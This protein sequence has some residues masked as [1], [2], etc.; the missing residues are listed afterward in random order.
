MEQLMAEQLSV[1]VGGVADATPVELAPAADLVERTENL[2]NHLPAPDEPLPGTIGR[3][4]L[5]FLDEI[6]KQGDANTVP[7]VEEWK[8]TA[9]PDRGLLTNAGERLTATVPQFSIAAMQ[10]G[11]AQKIKSDGKK[12]GYYDLPEGASEL[13]DLIEHKHMGFALAN[14]FKA[15]YRLGQKDGTDLLYDLNK[16]VYFAQER[17][18]PYVK[19]HGR[20][21]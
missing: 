8:P 2:L 16:I 6:Y 18:I 12:T 7:A 17:L 15:C 14:I 10:Q 19:K 11:D 1:P 21:P 5:I 4:E 3:Q 13:N 20:L 9:G